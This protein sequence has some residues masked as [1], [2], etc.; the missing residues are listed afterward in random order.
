[1][2]GNNFKVRSSPKTFFCICLHG[3]TLKLNNNLENFV[4]AKSVM[5]FEY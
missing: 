1:M 5:Q 4:N 2:D 3:D